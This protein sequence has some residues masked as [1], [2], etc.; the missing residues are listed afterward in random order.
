MKTVIEIKYNQNITYII[1]P[2]VN[3]RAIIKGLRRSYKIYEVNNYID[4]MKQ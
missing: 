4:V 1:N 2:V 3:I